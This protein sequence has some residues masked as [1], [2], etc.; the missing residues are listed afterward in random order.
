MET[1]VAKDNLKLTAHRLLIDEQADISLFLLKPRPRLNLLPNTIDIVADDLLEAKKVNRDLLLRSNLQPVL[2]NFDIAIVDTPPAMR[3]AT[4]NG[5]AVADT[6]ISSFFA[7]LKLNQ[8][9]QVVAAR[10]SFTQ[11]LHS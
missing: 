3:A 4:L 8:L 7:L 1:P 5:L 9:L 2:R 10:L 11:T 6:T